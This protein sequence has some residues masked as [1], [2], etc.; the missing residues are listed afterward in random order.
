MI[1]T[2]QHCWGRASTYDALLFTALIA[3]LLLYIKHLSTSKHRCL[4]D[5]T[6]GRDS[7]RRH[8]NFNGMMQKKDIKHVE[9]GHQS[10]QLLAI[11]PRLCHPPA[12]FTDTPQLSAGDPRGIDLL[13]WWHLSLQAPTAARASGFR[14]SP[15]QQDKVQT[16]APRQLITSSTVEPSQLEGRRASKALAEERG[17]CT[18]SAR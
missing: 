6:M 1:K 2:C 13:P 5:K 15:Q 14:R 16:L 18:E 11:S 7:K 12:V 9:G 3:V 10:S 8:P 17:G 4:K